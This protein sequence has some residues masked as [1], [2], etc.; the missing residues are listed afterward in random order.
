MAFQRA[1]AAAQELSTSHPSPLHLH[2]TPPSP[3]GSEPSSS[4]SDSEH[5]D[6]FLDDDDNM[7]TT[8][9]LVDV[10]AGLPEDFFRGSDNA[11]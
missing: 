7:S 5:S 11:K 4:V 9:A 3:P 10:K 6:I 8:T 2:S 1:L